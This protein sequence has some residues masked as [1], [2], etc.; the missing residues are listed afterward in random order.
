[1]GKNRTSRRRAL[2]ALAAVVLAAPTARGN[3]DLCLRPDSA[4]VPVNGTIALGLYAVA[5]GVADQHFRAVDVVFSW[6]ADVLRLQGVDNS[7]A[8]ALLYSG[9]PTTDPYHLNESVPP[10]DGDGFY[11]AWTSLT[12]PVAATLDGTLLTT[13][14]FEALAPTSAANVLLATSGGSPIGYTQVF[15]PDIPNLSV[16]GTLC[17]ATL[18]ITPE[19][20]TLAVL[21]IGAMAVLRKRSAR[22]RPHPVN[23]PERFKRVIAIKNPVRHVAP[24]APHGRRAE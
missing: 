21:A 10:Q 12:Q 17:G 20:G 5:D 7:G 22:W 9:L 14:W 18:V 16:L 19:P 24:H 13:F 4:I 3:I 6:E 11:N 23:Q 8:A 15:D 1:M 2:A